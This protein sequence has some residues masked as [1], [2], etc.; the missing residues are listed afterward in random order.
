MPAGGC[1]EQP[2]RLKQAARSLAL[3]VEA[4][5]FNKLPFNGISNSRIKVDFDRALLVIASGFY[6]RFANCMRGYA[7][8]QA[9]QIFQD[10]IDLPATV[11]VT[12]SQGHVTFHRRT[13]LPILLPSDL[14]SETPA[15]PWWH[16]A[17]LILQ[18]NACS[19]FIHRGNPG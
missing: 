7:D 18:A 6:R 8:A 15:V 3:E 19:R 14:F 1:R 17:R 10:L 9:R 2:G 16:G 12:A 11:K 4:G 13:H 5:L